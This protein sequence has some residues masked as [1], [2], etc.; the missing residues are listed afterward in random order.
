MLGYVLFTATFQL[1]KLLTTS[2]AAHEKSQTVISDIHFQL[3]LP[4]RR[5]VF[6]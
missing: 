4:V 2:L 6:A 5:N 3:R 1:T